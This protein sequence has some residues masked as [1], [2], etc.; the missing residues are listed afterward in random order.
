MNEPLRNAGEKKPVLK[1]RPMP[2]LRPRDPVQDKLSAVRILL[3]EKRYEAAIFSLQVILEHRPETPGAAELLADAIRL[4]Q[5]NTIQ[6]PSEFSLFT[7]F[8]TSHISSGTMY[9]L[10]RREFYRHRH[11]GMLKSIAGFLV[12]LGILSFFFIPGSFAVQPHF[13]KTVLP[14]IAAGLVLGWIAFSLDD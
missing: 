11:Q 12:F 14:L 4:K 3:N 6:S 1:Y 7:N 5:E 9:G 13:S 2:K 10:P 8:T